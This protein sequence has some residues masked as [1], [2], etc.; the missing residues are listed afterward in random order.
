MSNRDGLVTRRD[1]LATSSTV[2]AGTLWPMTIATGMAAE[3]KLEPAATV[4]GANR[5]RRLAAINS[6]YRL[7]SHAY[8]IIN[9]IVFGYPVDG[10]HHQPPFQIARMYNDQYPKD[11]LSRDFCPQH[12]IQ[13]CKTAAETLGA[14]GGLDVDG[15]LLIVEHG[16][17]PVNEFGQ[18][19][20]PRFELFQQV[21]EV[22]RKA[23]RSVPVFVD[24]HLSYDHRKAAAM[25]QNG[26]ELKFGMMSG[27]SLPVTW[28][29]PSIEPA[30]GTPFTEAVVCFGFDRGTPEIYFFHALEVLQCMLERRP[31]G[32]SGVKSVTCLQG[33][34]VW[35]AGDE[36]RWSWKLLDAAIRRN[37]SRNVG[38][39][40][41]NVLKPQALLVEYRDG[42]RG[43]VLNLIEQVAD[44]SFAA[45]IR[46]SD[47]PISTHFYL[48]PPPGA[49][50]FDPLTFNIEKFFAAGTSPYPVERTLLTSTMLDWAM[51]SLH[52]GGK[53]LSD[54]SLDIRYTAPASS[55]FFRGPVAE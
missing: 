53:T 25:I 21:V 23:G 44:F 46:G 10:V 8:H 24:K 38:P 52:T 2:M 49:K 19:Q 1:F 29:N 45:S 3:S 13:L 11:D 30:I 35:K 39:I 31:G 48:P 6:I 55:G 4:A 50:F 51:H 43:A 9:R 15:V 42:T 26:R 32:E 28:R 20:Y 36:G 7:R 17:Y 5:P 47:Q 33:D 18:V 12:G 41:E 54:P 34:A 40:R 27:S 37:P 16:D 22:F 14:N